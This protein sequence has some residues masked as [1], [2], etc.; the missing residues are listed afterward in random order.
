MILDYF[1]GGELFYHLKNDGKFSEERSRLYAAEIILALECLHKNNI[2]RLY[3]SSP[4][5]PRCLDYNS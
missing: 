1:T 2:V 4:F 5:S 3:Q